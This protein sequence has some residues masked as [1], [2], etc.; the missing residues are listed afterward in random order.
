[1]HSDEQRKSLPPEAVEVSATRPSVCNLSTHQLAFMNMNVAPRI[2]LDKEF[3][4]H[5]FHIA[6]TPPSYPTS[7]I[8][9]DASTQAA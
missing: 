5:I 9:K 7:I 3:T 4:K 6:S 2:N 8:L 1:M